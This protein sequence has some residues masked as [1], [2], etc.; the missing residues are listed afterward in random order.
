MHRIDSANNV[1]DKFGADKP[2]FTDRN[3]QTGVAGTIVDAKFLDAVQENICR[4]IEAAGIDLLD[5]DHQQLTN[6]I[7]KLTL[8][9]FTQSHAAN[10]YQRL[11]SGLLIQWGRSS[12]STNLPAPTSFS[13][14]VAGGGV[15][16]FPIAFTSAPFA[17][18]ATLDEFSGGLQNLEGYL[19]IAGRT[20]TSLSVAYTQAFGGSMGGET[21]SFDWIAIGV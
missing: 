9:G 4:A 18:T 7:R 1:P 20:Q 13:G 2:G 21:A 6:A 15:I 5:G 10:G 3:L 16:S 8:T 12:F 19:S 17:V 14:A 11:P